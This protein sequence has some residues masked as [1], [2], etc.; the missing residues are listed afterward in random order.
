MDTKG[1]GLVLSLNRPE[2]KLPD[3]AGVQQRYQP[4]TQCTVFLEQCTRQDI[5][6][7]VCQLL[8][9]VIIKSPTTHMAAAKRLLR[10]SKGLYHPIW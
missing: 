1:Q 6:Y 5:V 9:R 7:T 2:N 10:H 3:V 8:P 4:I